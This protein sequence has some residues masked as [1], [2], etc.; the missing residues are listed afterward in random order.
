MLLTGERADDGSCS[1]MSQSNRQGG[2]QQM[3]Q[4]SFSEGAVYY[5]RVLA[6]AAAAITVAF[7]LSILG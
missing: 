2:D 6:I 1:N 4:D 3:F 7:V 5:G